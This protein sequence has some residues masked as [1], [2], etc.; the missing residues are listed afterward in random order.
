[1]QPLILPMPSYMFELQK[2]TDKL[3]VQA[4]QYVCAAIRPSKPLVGVTP[5]SAQL[6]IS[7]MCV[8]LLVCDHGMTLYVNVF[9][10][11]L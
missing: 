2:N 5:S 10:F 3:L 8:P 4:M 7:E 11:I 1:M 6:H 9:V